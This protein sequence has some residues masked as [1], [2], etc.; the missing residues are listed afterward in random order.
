[1]DVSV[2]F[3]TSISFPFFVEFDCGRIGDKE[4]GVAV[5]DNDDSGRDVFENEEV[6][7]EFN[8]PNE[9]SYE[10]KTIAVKDVDDTWDVEGIDIKD[11]AVDWDVFF[12][13]DCADGNEASSFEE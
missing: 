6:S 5:E 4:V 8:D 12:A 2:F 11:N 3:V 7:F 1:M 9:N 13:I 10:Y